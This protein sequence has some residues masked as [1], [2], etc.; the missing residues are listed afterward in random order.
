[1][2]RTVESLAHKITTRKQDCILLRMNDSIQPINASIITSK[3]IPLSESI[4]SVRQ[5]IEAHRC[6]TV[7]S[8]NDHRSHFG[9]IL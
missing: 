8:I 3:N 1:M 5:A 6:D 2:V 4:A 9:P 7:S